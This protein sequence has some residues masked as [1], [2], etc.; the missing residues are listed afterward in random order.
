MFKLT[1]EQNAIIN[2]EKWSSAIIV[3]KAGSGKT[4]TI[5]Q[6]AIN[7]SEVIIDWKS[8][9]IISFTNKSVED[10]RKK[11][12]FS[13]AKNIISMTFH[14]FLMHHILSFRPLF[15]NKNISFDFDRKV[16]NLK[17]WVNYVN[18]NN[19]IPV[20]KDPKKDYLLEGAL[21]ALKQY[22]YIQKYLKYKFTAI[23]ID[24]AQDNNKLQYDIVKILLDLDIQVVLVG[25]ENQTIYQFRGAS[26][27]AFLKM[28]EHPKF[29]DNIYHLTKNFR[30]HELIDF[31]ANSYTVPT[32]QNTDENK[33]GI[34]ACKQTELTKIVSYFERKKEGIC[35][36][37]RGIKGQNNESNR[38]IINNYGLPI[39][40]LPDIIVKSNNPQPLT[41]L[42]HM[43]F[44][45]FKEE[46][47]FIE[48]VFPNL[49]NQQ[50]KKIIKDL[51]YTPS[52]ETLTQLNKYAL[53]Y[54]EKDFDEILNVFQND[55][56]RQFYTLDS[57]KNFA[58]TI[59]SAKGLEFKNVIVMSRDFN[60]LNY[61]NSKELFYVAC[62][63]AKEKLIFIN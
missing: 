20:S 10:I 51:K 1:D 22:P 37:F 54:E 45:S 27:D 18:T 32:E 16:S 44:G 56:A 11:L 17:E 53:I 14:S 7:Q 8:I 35:F 61:D 31:C 42:F 23:Y 30:C 36:L 63:R 3:A 4:T 15:R 38:Q 25:D 49:P 33:N 59:H 48:Y 60:N 9:A 52:A 57:I 41:L 50:A 62:T 28:K 29:Q 40:T 43:F 47:D 12:K 58:M 26:A 39:I 24:E 2:P 55:E 21:L 19:K 13:N 5:I 6:R 46:L 34:Y